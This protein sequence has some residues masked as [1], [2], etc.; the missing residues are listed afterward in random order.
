MADGDVVASYPTG[1]T[2]GWGVATSG[3]N[4]WLSNL[5]VAGGDDKDYQYDS[6]D[7]RPDGQRH[8]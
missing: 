1:I 3:A 7:G 6:S 2:F 8:R 4:I 5:G